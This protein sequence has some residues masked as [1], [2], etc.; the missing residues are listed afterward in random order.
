M[1]QN[2]VQSS[3]GQRP[4][5]SPFVQPLKISPMETL[6]VLLTPDTLAGRILK[7]FLKSDRKP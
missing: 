2:S 1:E 4:T 5:D 6:F 7:P 3:Q